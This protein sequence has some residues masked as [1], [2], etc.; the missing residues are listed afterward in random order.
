MGRL[1]EIGPLVRLLLERPALLGEWVA[2]LLELFRRISADS[3]ST[4]R[5]L[6]CLNWRLSSP[7]GWHSRL[8]SS[9]QCTCRPGHRRWRGLWDL[10][11][12]LTCCLQIS[13]QIV[14]G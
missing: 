3:Y 1:G 8:D 6:T 2:M 14:N 5:E 12:S 4:S 7:C 13:S 9:D 10:C 11:C